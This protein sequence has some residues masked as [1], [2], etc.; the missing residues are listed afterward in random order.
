MSKK[1]EKRRIVR[2]TTKPMRYQIIEVKEPKQIA[3]FESNYTSSKNEGA[4]FFLRAS[5]NTQLF[6]RSIFLLH[7]FHV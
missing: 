5:G 1:K 2:K 7:E 3:T 6:N 4:K